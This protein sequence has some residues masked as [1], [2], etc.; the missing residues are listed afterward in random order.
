INIGKLR[1]DKNLGLIGCSQNLFGLV[2]GKMKE[3]I[4]SRC[5]TTKSY[6]N[7]IIDLYESLENKVILNILDGIVACESNND[8]RIL[9]AILVSENPFAVD[10]AALRIINQDPHASLLLNEAVRRNKFD[11]NSEMLGDDINSLICHDFHYSM[12]GRNIKPGSDSAFKRAYKHSQQRPSI[13]SKLCMGC[14][15]CVSAC[16]MKAIN[17]TNTELGAH[18]VIDYNKCISC[19]NCA[20]SCPY[21]IIKTKSPIK[22][23]LICKSIKKSH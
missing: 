16:P 2:P 3:L 4:K 7:Y 23:K 18:A 21:K 14:K 5:Y 13:T 15:V 22:Y 9:N 19:F 12:P 1:C 10:K 8:P 6:Y 20:H 11:F 17:M